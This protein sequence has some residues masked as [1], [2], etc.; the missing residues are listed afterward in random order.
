MPFTM[1]D[2]DPTVAV[3]IAPEVQV[4]PVVVLLN[5]VDEPAQTVALPVMGDNNGLTVIVL[6]TVHPMP[7]V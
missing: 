1:P 2:N 4:P 5:V 7:T 6:E 3:N